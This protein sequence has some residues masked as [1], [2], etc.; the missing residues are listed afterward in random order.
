MSATQTN[1]TKDRIIEATAGLLMRQGLSGTGL[2]QISKESGAALGSLYHFFPGGKDDLAAD[3]LRVAGRSYLHL[4]DDYFTGQTDLVAATEGFF[5]GAAAVLE[6]T[7]Y[8]DACPIA[9]VALE[10]ASTNDTLR[11][12]TADVFAEWVDVA[13]ERFAQMGVE[14]EVARELVTLTIAALEGGFLL[15]RAAKSTDAMRTIGR[16]MAALVARR[17]GR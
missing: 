14:R 13:T 2:K 12:V 6:A 1:T 7:D 3:A 10:V 16:S 9:T 15:C 5:E 11:Q 8:A 4:I 17:L